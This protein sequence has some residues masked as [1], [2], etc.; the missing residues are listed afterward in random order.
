MKKKGS[1]W[2]RGEATDWYSV[3][4]PGKEGVLGKQ[5]LKEPEKVSA[6]PTGSLG[7]KRSLDNHRKRSASVS[8][9]HSGPAWNQAVASII[10]A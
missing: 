6:R 1:C 9:V 10:L 7:L 8:L 2:R 3:L 5:C 4:T